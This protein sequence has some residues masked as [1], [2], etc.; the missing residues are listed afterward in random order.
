MGSN[1]K[2]FSRLSRY[3]KLFE[4][5]KMSVDGH[6]KTKYHTNFRIGNAVMPNDI[7]PIF[8]RQLAEW[9]LSW[10]DNQIP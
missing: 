10:K 9:F 3:R 2:L 5:D 1:R 7:K 4:A 6:S 8:L